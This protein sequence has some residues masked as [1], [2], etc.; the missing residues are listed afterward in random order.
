MMKDYLKEFMEACT[1]NFIIQDVWGV[2]VPFR[3]V[4]VWVAHQS[5]IT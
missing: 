1:I 3:T 4:E 5:L 2:D